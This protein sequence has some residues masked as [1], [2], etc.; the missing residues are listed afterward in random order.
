MRSSRTT[1][2]WGGRRGKADEHSFEQ[3]CINFANEK[4]QQHFNRTTF[5]EEEELYMKEGRRGV[6]PPLLSHL[7]TSQASSSSTSSSSTTRWCWT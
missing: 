7:T 1:G 5:K 6:H 3:L 2:K 4:L